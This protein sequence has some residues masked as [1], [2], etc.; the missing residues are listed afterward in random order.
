M[1]LASSVFTIGHQQADG[2]RYVLERHTAEDGE[3][4]EYEYLSNGNPNPQLVMDD[5]AATINANLIGLG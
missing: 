2:R 3:I 1:P 5:R 4:Y